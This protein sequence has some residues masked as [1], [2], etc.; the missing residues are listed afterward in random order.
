MKILLGCSSPPDQGAGGIMVYTSVLAEHLVSLGVD[1]HLAAPEPSDWTWCAKFNIKHV[2]TCQYDDPLLATRTLYEYIK[3]NAI[4]GIIN[5]DN[6]YIQSVLPLVRCPSIVIGHLGEGVIAALACYQSEWSDYIIPISNDMFT[7]FVTKYKVP[8]VKCPI[9]FNGVEDKGYSKGY[10]PMEP[11]K[12]RVVFA[13]GYNQRKGAKH[14]LASVIKYPERWEGCVL[15]WFGNLPD[16]IIQKIS[17]LKFVQHRGKVDR[18]TFLEALEISDILMFP[19]LS[20]GC[21]MAMLEAMSLAVVPIASDGVGAMSSL[22]V[23]GQEGYICHLNSWPDEATN[24][25]QFLKNNHDILEKLKFKSR[26]T[27][28]R[29][30]QSSIFV[31]RLIQLLSHPTVNRKF[32][33]AE[34]RVLHWHRPVP[35]GKKE[36]TFVNKIKIYAGVLNQAGYLRV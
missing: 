17:H 10:A 18:D 32:P 29:N 20:E 31:D 11:G 35:K 14:I 28:L 19:S 8:V 23:N 21:P 33:P 36:A 30:Y 1:V 7:T 12:L 15:D 2:R 34:V 6:P 5:N 16:R 25:L 13:G 22:V 9:V 24:C 3:A 26:E 27:F 4:D